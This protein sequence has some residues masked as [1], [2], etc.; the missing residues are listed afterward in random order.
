MLILGDTSHHNGRFP[1][2]TGALVLANI[3]AFML[4]VAVGERLT[5]GYSL[6]PAE[7]TEFKDIVKTQHVK[8]KVTERF[9]DR[10]GIEHRYTQERYIPVHHYPGPVPIVLTLL[11]S[12]F[13][14]AGIAHLVGNMW[15]L[16]VF[17]RN[18]ECALGHV[19]FLV[20]Y[21]I[22]GVAGGLAHIASDAHSLIPCLGASG[23]ISGVLGAYVAIHPL[24]N[25]KCWFGWFIGVIELPA[26]VVI[27]VW[28]L[29]Q[30][31]FAFMSLDRQE[32]GG[33]A[34]WAHLGGFAMGIGFIWGTVAYLKWRQAS[35]AAQED[36]IDAPTDPLSQPASTAA[37][38]FGSFLP[39]TG[40]RAGAPKAPAPDPF[41]SFLPGPPPT[42][43]KS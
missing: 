6:V 34:Y 25:I 4:Q 40:I 8:I 23:A 22:C 27:G 19:R 14:H 38:P 9:R 15:F 7:I 3:A 13:L 26:L 33:T 35:A 43:V 10:G 29:F 20:F 32:G 24:N 39:P 12:M 37:D 28:F 1:W 21:L 42:G 41:T 16:L 36:E 31:L 30:Y 5:N 2:V 18:V 17:G 11:T